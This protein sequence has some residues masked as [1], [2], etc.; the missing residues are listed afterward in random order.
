MTGK[1]RAIAASDQAVPLDAP[2]RL[3]GRQPP[4]EHKCPR[5][6]QLRLKRI[7]A[8]KGRPERAHALPAH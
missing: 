7:A 1:Q 2:R 3:R 4:R 6:R 5:T 8:R